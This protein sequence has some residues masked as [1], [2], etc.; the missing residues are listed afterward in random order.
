MIKILKTKFEVNMKDTIYGPKF[1]QLR[2]EQNITLE[3]AAKGITSRSTLSLWEN[4]NDNLSF[5][6]VLTLLQKIHEQP[7]EFI[8]HSISPELRDLAV[9]LG[10]LY[11]QSD[12]HS[13]KKYALTKLKSSNAQ[14]QNKIVFL[15]AC[16]ACNFYTDLTNDNLLTDRGCQ[17][18]TNILANISEWNYE[19]IYYFGNTSG[20]IPAQNIYRLTISLINY[21]INKKL[22]TK[23]WYDDVIV[24]VS[25][26]IAIL[27]KKTTN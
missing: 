26:S 11:I 3:Q 2:K 24:G 1:R 7:I 4:G 10:K 9:E 12:T 8:T 14:P 25:N 19:N 27:L 18:L 23:R 13:L 6:Q 16:I 5:L 17:R 21:S 15:E 20:L 22:N